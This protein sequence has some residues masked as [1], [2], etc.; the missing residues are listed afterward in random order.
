MTVWA[1]RADQVDL[2]GPNPHDL[3]RSQ[4]IAQERERGGPEGIVPSVLRAIHHLGLVRMQPESDLAEPGSDPIPR[5]TGLLLA[6]AVHHNVITIPLERQTRELPSHPPSR[7]AGGNLT[8][9]LPQIR[10]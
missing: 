1:T 2:R 8:R 7:V 10:T 5:V 3:A 9:R 4:G 6:D